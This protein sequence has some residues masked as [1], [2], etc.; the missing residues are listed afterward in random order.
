MAEINIEKKKNSK[1]VWPWIL[2]AL[3]LIGIIWAVAEMGGDEAE[4]AEVAAVEEPYEEAPVV[5]DP[6][7]NIIEEAPEDFVSYVEDEEIKNRMGEDHQVTGEALIKLSA[8]LEELSQNNNA[9]SQ[10]INDIREAGQEIQSEPQSQQH[11]DKV[12]NAFISVANV[13]E[14]IKQNQYPDAQADVEGLQEKASEIEA[15][16]QLTEQKEVIQDFF[17]KTADAIEQMKEGQASIM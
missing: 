13:L 4:V 16:K 3:V 9:Y 1:P 11:A 14:Q 5:T 15:D 10:E 8:S 12:Q 17:E 7:A 2:A 6:Q